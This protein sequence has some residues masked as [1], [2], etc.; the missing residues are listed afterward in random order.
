LFLFLRL[1][2]WL[3]L[4]YLE[5]IKKLSCSFFS[6]IYSFTSE[7]LTI[8]DTKACRSGLV[9]GSY[10]YHYLYNCY[11]IL[12]RLLFGFPL[13]CATLPFYFCALLWKV[14]DLTQLRSVYT[15]LKKTPSWL[16]LITI[17]KKLKACCLITIICRKH[18]FGVRLR[19]IVVNLYEW[20]W[21]LHFLLFLFLFCL[22]STIYVTN[23]K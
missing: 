19:V 4:T 11:F 8:F 22:V 17:K 21:R 15:W 7:F 9:P 10:Y 6:T 20:C 16:A 13:R 14:E 23:K 2:F 18:N 5:Y 12:K 1:D 3:H